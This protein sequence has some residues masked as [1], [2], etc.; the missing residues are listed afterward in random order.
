MWTHLIGILCAG[1]FVVPAVFDYTELRRSKRDERAGDGR[2][3][4]ADE[5][6]PSRGEPGDEPAAAT[7]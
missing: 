6:E 4:P 1:I 3:V 7:P 2:R 5:P